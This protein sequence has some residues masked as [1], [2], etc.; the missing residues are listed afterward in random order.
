MKWLFVT[1]RFAYPLS[2][3]TYLRTYHLARE[4]RRGGDEVSLLSY[5]GDQRGVGVYEREGI[6]I[7]SPVEG[8]PPT[9][10]AGRFW[11]SPY[12]YS[13][14]LATRLAECAADFD[15]V[16]LFG[17]TTLQYAPETRSA[18]RVI[19]D[20]VDDPLI[21]QKRRMTSRDVS[22]ADK[23]RDLRFAFGEKRYEKR[24]A[25]FVDMI[26]FV[27]QSDADNFSQR[28]DAPAVKVVT[29]G[30]DS[31]YFRRPP[32]CEA[33]TDPVNVIFTGVMSNPNNA[34][35]AE[36]LVQQIAP[37]IWQQHPD[38][39]IKIVGAEPAERLL[40]LRCDR[41][42]VTGRVDDIRTY[43]L[44]ATVVLLPML[45]GTGIKNKLLEAWSSETAVVGTKL[46]ALA[47]PAADNENILLGET[48]DSLAAAT[49]KLLT[50]AQLREKIARTARELVEREFTWSGALN[51]MR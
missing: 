32:S 21:E 13:N 33:S 7:L 45:S 46:C 22:L 36:F 1:S 24:Y 23:F 16:I 40:K 39:K 50:D 30:V 9:C 48:P 18:G 41:V 14:E 2:H 38:V 20:F 42:D 19:C 44:D 34:R 25:K 5:A 51:L 10:G 43:L 11:M 35:A 8:T 28:C 31:D 27:A 12:V 3:G 47:T 37:K 29:N 6:E 15:A 49:C 26:T 4:A 17:A